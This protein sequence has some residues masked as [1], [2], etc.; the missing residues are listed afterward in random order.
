[1]K[2]KGQYYKDKI[3]DGSVGGLMEINGNVYR[4]GENYVN[5]FN[6]KCSQLI[7]IFSIVVG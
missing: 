6:R 5:K 1:M 4:Q 3:G 7:F 2:N